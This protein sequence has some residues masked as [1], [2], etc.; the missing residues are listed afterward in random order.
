MLWLLFEPPSL[1]VI[2]SDQGLAKYS[3]WVKSDLSS[4]LLKYSHAHFVIYFLTAYDWFHTTVT[5]W[6]V[7]IE[8]I[9]PTKPNINYPALCKKNWLVPVLYYTAIKH[10]IIFE[11]VPKPLSYYHFYLLIYHWVL[12]FLSNCPIF[13]FQRWWLAQ[14]MFMEINC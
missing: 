8:I 12:S 11:N 13:F 9:W 4:I 7:M 14:V 1:R 10:S 6:V 5:S 3:L 2:S